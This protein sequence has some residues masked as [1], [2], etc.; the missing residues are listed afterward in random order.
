MGTVK[1]EWKYLL[2]Q[3]RIK[4]NKTELRTEFERDYQSILYSTAFRRLIDKTQVFPLERKYDT[5]RRRLTHSYEVADLARSIGVEIHDKLGISKNLNS[6]RNLPALLCAL[7]LAHDLGNPPFG[8]KGEDAI[9]KWFLIQSNK[10]DDKLYLFW[11]NLNEQQRND[12]LKF[13]GNAQSFRLV[14]KLQNPSRNGLNLTF[15]TLSALLKY[16]VPSNETQKDGHVAK[17]KTGFFYS[18]QELVNRIWEKTKLYQQRHPLTYILEAC[19]DIAYN[20]LDIEDAV[21]KEVVS[22][23]ELIYYLESEKIVGIDKILKDLKDSYKQYL[24]KFTHL[25]A[26]DAAIQKCSVLF[27]I[28]MTK[29][30]IKTFEKKLDKIISKGLDK[31]LIQ[32]CKCNDLKEAL[33]E[34][35]QKRI[36]SNK[37]II[38]LELLGYNTI[39]WLMSTFWKSLKN[40]DQGNDTPYDSY[41]YKKIS[42][43]Y[44][45]VYENAIQTNPVPKRYAQ[46]QLITDMVSGMTD[47]YAI[48]LMED[49]KSKKVKS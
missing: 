19:D 10:K 33:E 35:C 47:R 18:E 12:F 2:S 43:S 27:I 37:E 32:Y 11:D 44:R 39:Q 48:E 49:L 6:A 5:V 40:I 16:V 41:V 3:K 24:K 15:G 38:K 7:G 42:E 34:F 8:H 1:K 29:S 30:V 45:T 4:D 22:F 31:S 17:K 46:F 14:T 9:K 13:D 25:E 26:S 21:K 36:F 28:Y 20:I 23:S